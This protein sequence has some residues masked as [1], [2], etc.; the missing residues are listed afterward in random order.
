L[1]KY[2][3]DEDDRTRFDIS[4]INKQNEGLLVAGEVFQGE[5]HLLK[6]FSLSEDALAIARTTH[7]QR[8]NTEVEGIRFQEHAMSH[9]PNWEFLSENLQA[10][11]VE[12][13]FS[14]GIH[15]SLGICLEYLSWNKEQRLYMGWLKD[16]NSLLFKT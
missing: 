1:K 5:L 8:L 11:L 12:Y 7:C 15:P 13:L 3:D 9:A 16:I 6:V 4:I 10:A 14:V 2:V